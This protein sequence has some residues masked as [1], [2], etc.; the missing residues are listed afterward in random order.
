MKEREPENYKWWQ[1]EIVYQI[2]PRSYK[3]N[4]GDGIGDLPGIIEKLDY[5]KDLGIKVIWIS[6]IYPSPMADFGYDV[7]DYTGI[8]PMFG[9][10]EDFDRLL[11]EIHKRNMKLIL[12]FVP[13]HSSNMHEW[14]QE[15]RKSKDSPKR[16]C[17]IWKDPA[18][19]GGPPN[20]W[21]SVFGGSGWEYDEETN[22]Y[23]Y[24]AFL[25]EQPDLN[26]RNPEV[27]EAMFHVMRFWLEK[28]VD[29]F[30]V[31]VMWHL[32]KDDQ[33]RDNPPN[34]DYT[35]DYSPYDKH[36]QA[37]TT[38]Q[39]EVHDIVEK[40]R[41]VIDE[42]DER[43]LIGEIYLPV[44]QLVEYYG[45]DNRGAHL[46]FNFQLVV[47]PWD[48][49]K[50]EAAINKYEGALPPE[51]WPNWV[52]GNHDNSRI[53]TRVGAKQARIAAMLLLTLR[54]TPTIYY[55]DEIGM[56]DVSIAP[57]QVQDP[58]EKNIPG[59]G[60]NRDPERTPMQW[61]ASENAGF[62]NGNPWLPLM[63]NFKE[64]NVEK[65]WDSEESMLSFYRKLIALRQKEPA[66]QIGNYRPVLSK[67]NL[68]AYIRSSE[69]KK[70]FI[71][72]NLGNSG[73]V[74]DSEIPFSKA[75]ILAST[76]AGREGKSLNKTIDLQAN[77]GL[78]A[79]ITE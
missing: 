18:P 67:G 49:R 62:T 40:M 69:E 6:P 21:L 57:D 63:G 22:Q 59:K 73:A 32:I 12:D 1:K 37:F 52:L 79:E 60:L 42:Y 76:H 14:F 20:N 65:Q 7:S 47:L 16:D 71:T 30:R 64:L 75:V 15:S 44:E 78:V 66:L 68:L 13:N 5:I 72:L 58:Q 27:Q 56:E 36:L 34:P 10:M 39:P 9:T 35:K 70:I 53:A 38:D 4:S 55:G 61:N 24:H 31:D 17:Y 51:G 25:K 43:L 41:S 46:P 28:G 3:D 50:I 54:G 2:Y 23:Y 77:E 26:W 33:F 45:K 19:D 8:H 11:D 29:G 48:A 74:M